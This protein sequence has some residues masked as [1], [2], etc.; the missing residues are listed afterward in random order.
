M[1][2]RL[3]RENVLGLLA[4]LSTIAGLVD[5]IGFLRLGHVF[6]AHI[7]GNLV[8]LLAGALGAGPAPLAQF[9]SIP[10][11]AVAVAAAYLVARRSG[12]CPGRELLIAQAVLLFLVL[13]LAL[14]ER[15]E[16]P[17][18]VV[19]TA[20][21]AVAAVAFQNA[22]IRASLHEDWVTSVMTGNV[23]TAIVALVGLLR[24]GP[25][26]REESLRKLRTTAPLVLGFMAGC[27]TGATSASML[28]AWAW[29]LPAGLSVVAVAT[30]TSRSAC[31]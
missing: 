21:T 23:A 6:T 18:L 4:L 19:V 28:G 9:L 3:G 25:W 11:F 22:F 20:M 31:Q 7:T 16:G 29:S 17:S 13:V 14:K 30:W 24:P 1:K 27:L 10:V 2:S 12:P 26:T 8:L 15:E 5:V